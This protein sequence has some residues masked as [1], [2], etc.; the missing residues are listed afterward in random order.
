MLRLYEQE[1]FK[2]LKKRSTLILVVLLVMQNIVFAI[3]ADVDST[4]FIPKRLFIANFSTS[5][6]L[7]LVMI[8]AAAAIITSEFE[9]D[10]LKNLVPHATSRQ[11]IIISKW[12]AI[13]TYSL[14][15]YLLI[16]LLSLLNKFLFFNQ[17]FALTDKI[18][19]MKIPIWQQWL[20]TIAGDY[21]N[22]WLILSLVFLIAAALKKSSTAIS[23]GIVGYFSLTIIGTL[24]FQL[25]KKWE[26]LKWNPLNFLNYPSQLIFPQIVGKMTR[27]ST[28]QLLWGNLVY[29]I[30]FLGIGLYFFSRK[31]A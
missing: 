19:G 1:V 3:F 30:I 29:I 9:Y 24:M 28:T 8:A 13:L 14:G 4:H 26:F 10:T 12:L 25:I 6:Y 27:L 31:E 15:L 17:T 2:L 21:V 22:L 16:S 20:I 11:A 23:L 18:A 7:T 5:S